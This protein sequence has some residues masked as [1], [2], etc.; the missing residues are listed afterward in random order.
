MTPIPPGP[1]QTMNFW[2]ARTMRTAREDADIKPR[3]VSEL[4]DIDPAGI[5]R[6]EA[7]AVQPKRVDQYLAAY[8]YLLGVDDPREFYATALRLWYKLGEAPALDLDGPSQ[9]TRAAVERAVRRTRQSR[10]ARP[11]KRDETPKKREA[12]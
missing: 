1:G 6:F 10:D 12:G 4:L 5:R 11:G 7:A 9:R 3:K 8:A 2:L